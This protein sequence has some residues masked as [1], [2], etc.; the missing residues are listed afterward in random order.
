MQ[1]GG[2]LLGCWRILMRTAAFRTIYFGVYNLL[3]NPV[4]VMADSYLTDAEP[5]TNTLLC[6][7]SGLEQVDSKPLAFVL[8]HRLAAEIGDDGDPEALGVGF[9]AFS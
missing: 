7:F 8:A 9:G 2:F 1:L 4:Q 6:P 3:I 5:L